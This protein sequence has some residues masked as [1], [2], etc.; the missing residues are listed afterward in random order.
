MVF[1]SLSF[2]VVFLPVLIIL[3]FVRRQY[4][5]LAF[6]LLFYGAGEPKY[7]FLI[8]ACVLIT[9][10][11][12]YFVERKE[13][14]ALILAVLV[15]IIPLIVTKYSGFIIRNT[16][17]V[18]NLLGLAGIPMPEIIMPIG[19]S[20]Y[21]FQVITYIVDLYRGEIKRQKNPLLF[22]LY[23]MFF[24]QLIAG[25][26]V[27]YSEVANEL[28]NPD[29]SLENVKYGIGRLILGLGKKV[30]IANQVGFIANAIHL[31]DINSISP[32]MAWLCTLAFT[33]QIYFDFSG[34]SDMAIGLGA[35]FGFHFPENFN[36]PYTSD[37][38]SEF[39]RRWHITLGRFFR[40]YVYIPLGGNRVTKNRWI[41]NIAVVWTL[42]GLWHGASWN[43]VIW[44]AFHGVLIV[45][46][47][48]TGLTKKLPKFLAYLLTIFMITVSW[49]FFMYDSI[50]KKQMMIFIGKLFFISSEVIKPVSIGSLRLWSYIPFLIVGIFLSTPLWVKIR[51]K[52]AK[53]DTA[54]AKIL[55]DIF[56]IVE[57]LF[58]LMFLLGS[59]YNPFIYFRF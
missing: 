1:S 35:I 3:Y 18:I 19:I 52:I 42:T 31:S 16:N 22:A 8:M 29:V 15:N 23:V 27:K 14:L 51:T 20:F 55:F 48:L 50:S 45:I 21:T 53:F 24:P 38:I 32:V 58:S 5:L 33:I 39:W 26:I 13:K 57:L 7:I 30:L 40:E 2:L 59:T 46:D 56:L 44:G 37:S 41:M 9:W 4:V 54:T 11:L 17:R 49:V 10:F 12:S 28:E 36:D 25:P 47:R 34:Y 43:F 6:S